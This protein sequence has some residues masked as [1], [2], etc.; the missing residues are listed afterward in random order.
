MSQ[1]QDPEEK[2]RVKREK[3]FK[4]LDEA[5]RNDMMSRKDPEIDEAIKKSAI[6]LVQL[7]L[8][9]DMDE[10]L[11]RLKEE[12]ATANAQYTDG[13]KDNLIRI[14]FL[15]QLLKSRG[16]DVPDIKTLVKSARNL[17]ANE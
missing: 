10:D 11:L 1:I 5:W 17:E 8:A 2:A 15:V 16:R 3:K 9:K 14:E 12:L 6:A 7:E 4:K 13:K